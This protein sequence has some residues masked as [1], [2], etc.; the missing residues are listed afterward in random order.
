MEQ[1]EVVA[2]RMEDLATAEIA[3]RVARSERTV[4]GPWLE[5]AQGE[6]AALLAGESSEPERTEA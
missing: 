5:H 2:L 4:H 3:K 6:L 1:R